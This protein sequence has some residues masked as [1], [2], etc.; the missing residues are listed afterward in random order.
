VAELK[1]D[2]VEDFDALFDYFGADAVA[3]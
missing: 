1:G 2:L 3:V